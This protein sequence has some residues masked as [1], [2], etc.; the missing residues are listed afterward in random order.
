[1]QTDNAP[2]TDYKHT[3]ILDSSGKPGTLAALLQTMSLQSSSVQPF[4]SSAGGVDIEVV[5]GA[6]WNPPAQ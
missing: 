3:V 2:R 4:P 1:V 6:D 5:I